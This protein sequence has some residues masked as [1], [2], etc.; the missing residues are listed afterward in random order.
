MWIKY[1]ELKNFQNLKTGLNA[2]RLAI[3]FSN[4]ENVICLFVGPNGIGKTSLL[5][6]LTPFATLGNLDIRD[7]NQLIIH[8]KDGYKK[9]I[10]V[11]DDNEYEIEHFYTATKDTHSIKSYFKLNGLELN[12]NGNVTSFKSTVNEI[13]H[14]DMDYLKLIRIGDNVTNLMNMKATERKN[15]MSK[16]LSSVEVYLKYYKKIGD[17]VRDIKAIISHS[18]DKLQKLQIDDVDIY[19]N[20]LKTL[21]G[22]LKSQ[23]KEIDDLKGKCSHI[24]INLREMGE[25]NNISELNTKINEKKKLLAKWEKSLKEKT[26][27]STYDIMQRKTESENELHNIE[28]LLTGLRRVQEDNMNQLDSYYMELTKYKKE[29]EIEKANSNIDAIDDYIKTLHKKREELEEKVPVKICD[30]T[31]IEVEEFI[32]ALKNIQHTLLITYEFGLEPISEA[33]DLIEKNGNIQEFI[34]SK[35]IAI[36]SKKKQDE[37]TYLDKLVDKYSNLINIDSLDNR[38]D[39]CQLKNLYHDIMI[40]KTLKPSDTKKLKSSD[41]YQMVNAVYDNLNFVLGELNKLS[42]I[43]KRLPSNI[44]KDFLLDTVFH[45]IRKGKM[46][47]DDNKIND[48]LCNVTENANYDEV[49]QKLKDAFSE[50]EKSEA[51]SSISFLERSIVTVKEK[52]EEVLKKKEETSLEISE[53]EDKIP[54]LDESIISDTDLLDAL[55]KYSSVEEEY[56]EL[57]EKSEKINK[58]L[59][60]YESLSKTLTVMTEKTQLLLLMF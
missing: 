37:K 2:N 60:D 47:Y 49:L 22:A 6:C 17:D 1:I 30:L 54:I 4:R 7:G 43:I 32:I 31:K 57:L 25:D 9:I 52:I 26:D 10:I 24:K 5:S 39:G 11:N 50:K 38:C 13:L 59:S 28:G 12:P 8:G 29:L 19:K 40:V 35:L 18:N 20:E 3:D 23:E 45:N 55:E 16:F 46:I 56:K 34:A 15:F 53:L 48:L 42:P 33:L 51:S 21:Q 14:I 36:E 41:Y 58:Y 44:Q 27:I